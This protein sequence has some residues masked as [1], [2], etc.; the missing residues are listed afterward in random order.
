MSAAAQT[1]SPRGQAQ[2]GDTVG[3]PVPQLEAA[4]KLSGSAQYIADLYR[5]GMLH[6][7]M[8]SET[9]QA[10]APTADLRT[11]LEKA[12][13]AADVAPAAAAEGP[14]AAPAKVDRGAQLRVAVILVLTLLLWM[15]D[16][17]HGIN[18]AWIGIGTAVL[19]LAP[20]IGVVGP[21]AFKGA[22]DFGLLLFV[23]G[24]LALGAVVDGSGLGRLIGGFLE[25]ALPLAPGRDFV[26]FLSLTVMSFA[27]GMV[28]TV[29]SVPAVLTP[30]AG[31]LAHLSG[32]SLNAVLMTEVVGFSTVLFPYQ[33]G[34]LVVA[35]QLSGER[36]DHLLRITV[37]LTLIT[38]LALAPIVV[39]WWKLLGWL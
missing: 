33:V 6:G 21:Q 8:T 23:A 19:L 9:L 25:A 28:T 18:S 30:M 12:R 16:K 22:V 10:L 14:K 34:P 31:D 32:F 3:H 15:S 7:A 29:P 5:P 37:P 4:E 11:R 13:Q 38:L 36:L 2:D 24:A 39:L 1:Q 20:R 17:L 35:M 27:S 26:N